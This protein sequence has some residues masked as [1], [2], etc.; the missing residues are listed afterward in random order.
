MNKIL[1]TSAV[2]GAAVLAAVTGSFAQAVVFLPDNPTIATQTQTNDF[3]RAYG[4]ATS[5][6]T[7]RSYGQ[8]A[9]QARQAEQPAVELSPSAAG[10]PAPGQIR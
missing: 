1:I 9:V 10:E 3:G 5:A 8:A 6:R 7:V 2:A 4:Q